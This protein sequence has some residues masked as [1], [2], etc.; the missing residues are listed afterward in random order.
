MVFQLPDS[1]FNVI[2]HVPEC[3]LVIMKCAII[4]MADLVI[5]SM[6]KTGA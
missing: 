4:Y 2:F 6:F 5:E 1:T 3:G